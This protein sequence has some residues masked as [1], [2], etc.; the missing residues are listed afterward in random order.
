ASSDQHRRTADVVANLA[1]AFG[2]YLRFTYELEVLSL[3]EVE[4]RWQQAWSAL[5][6]AAVT[7]PQHQVA[8]EPTTRFLRLLSAALVG[9]H[10]HLASLTGDVPDDPV[11]SGWRAKGA[12]RDVEWH[13][14]GDRVGWVKDEDVYLEPE[15]AYAAV[16]RL[17]RS[18]EEA[19]P[20][21]LL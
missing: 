21:G 18:G 16:Q 13:A 9:G 3:E 5:G 7:Q 15:M 1:T 4:A 6:K 20:I 8:S 19:L 10:A 2:W 11:G 14:Q 17:A 12:G